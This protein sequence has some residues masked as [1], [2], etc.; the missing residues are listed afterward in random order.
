MK[1]KQKAQAGTFESGDIMILIEPV[2]SGAGREIIIDSTVAL[3]FGDDIKQLI[4][5]KLDEFKVQDV[6]LM[7]KDKG[8][9]EPTIKA[10]VETALIRSAN[11]Q[12]GT[13]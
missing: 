5:S 1:I 8:A 3:Q 9:L 12:E 10:R 4:I 7:A 6:H 13:L 11:Q 2:P